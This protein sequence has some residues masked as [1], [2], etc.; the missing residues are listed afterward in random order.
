MSH[1]RQRPAKRATIKD[2]AQAAGVSITTVSNVLNDRTEAMTGATL[3]RIQDT[4]QAL[5]YRPNKVAR[6]LVTKSTAT[7]GVIVVEIET[8]LFLQALN[9]IEPIAR[10]A[11]HNILLCTTAHDLHDEAQAV[12]LLLEKQIDGLIFLST[13]VYA[14]HNFLV[15]LPPLSPPVVLINRAVAYRE[16]VDQISFDNVQGMIE[17]VDHLVRLGHTRIA[18]LSGPITRHS[19]RQRLEGYRLGLEKH[20]LPYCEAYVRPADYQMPQELWER[21]T[22]ELLDV[23]PRPTAIIGANDVVAATAMRTVQQAGLRVPEDINVVGIDD[24]PFCT[25][26]NPALTTL[27]LPVLEA[28][29]L[30]IEMLLARIGGKRTATEHLILPCSLVEREST[31]LTASVNG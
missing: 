8:P 3:Q 11:N 20:G 17:A 21:S 15:H 14:D 28:G 19:S 12:S 25:Y 5:D 9:V 24:Q 31:G 4:I 13:S 27:Q 30:A 16:G 18:H 7:I 22:L 6:S 26:L 23:D 1:R 10:S 2:V 29:K